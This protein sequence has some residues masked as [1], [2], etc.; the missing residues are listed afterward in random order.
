MK[1]VKPN[2]VQEEPFRHPLFTSDDATRQSLLPESVE[3]E[4]HQVNFGRGVSL[5]LHAHSNEQIL[6][7]TAGKGIV[8]TETEEMVVLPGDVAYFPAGEPHWHGAAPDSEHSHIY[9]YLKGT[10]LV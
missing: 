3:Y 4:I 5:K 2:D 7:A 8:A 10:K 1:V 6:I 9:I